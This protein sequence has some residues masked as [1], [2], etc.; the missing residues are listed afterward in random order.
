MVMELSDLFEFGGE[1]LGAV[2]RGVCLPVGIIWTIATLPTVGG[3]NEM[4]YINKYNREHQSNPRYSPSHGYR[5]T[6]KTPKYT[7]TTP[8]YNKYPSKSKSGYVSPT[9]GY[10]R[11]SAVNPVDLEYQRLYDKY[12]N[13]KASELAKIGNTLQATNNNFFDKYAKRVNAVSQKP[14]DGDKATFL[15]N[16]YKWSKKK[17]N[18]GI[19]EI[20]VG[21]YAKGAADITL[22]TGGLQLWGSYFTYIIWPEGLWPKV[23]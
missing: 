2:V 23:K 1:A 19:N 8:K 6:K 10:V 17:I 9:K 7:K 5:P 3:Q 11:T 22:G 12:L 20:K 14:P 13:R 21:N 16:L 18:T 15:T 4:G